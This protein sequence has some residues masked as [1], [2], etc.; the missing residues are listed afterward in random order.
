MQVTTKPNTAKIQCAILGLGNQAF[1]HLQACIDH[2]DITIVAGIERDPSIWHKAEH[3]FPSLD[4]QCFSDLDALKASDLVIDAF[5]LALPHHIYQGIWPSLMQW[6]KPLLKEKPLG[7]D[8][9]EAK[10]FMQQSK[11]A[12]CG[13]QT[14]IQRRQHPSY[15][16]LA[17]YLKEHKL[18][19]TEVH[20]HLHLGKGQAVPSAEFDLGWRG[21]RSQAG[22]GALLDAGYHLIDLVQFLIGDFEV[23]SSTMWHGS[24]ADNGQDIE[25]RSWLTGC[26]SDTW[27]MI[28]TWVKGESNHKGGYLKS[29]KVILQTHQG[30]LSANREGVWLNEQQLFSSD[31]EWQHAMR[32]QLADFAKSIITDNWHNDVIWDQLPAMRKIEE[33]YRLSSRY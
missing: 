30:V 25:D 18:T 8:Y 19:P 7:R 22:G 31:R 12:D 29:E 20:A 11:A 17:R 32:Q 16:F 6:G 2:P 9:Q 24:Q 13:L 23:I 1:E 27:L 4:L 3:A 15:Q 33:A 10:H 26:S 28:D 21:D 14:A 5:I